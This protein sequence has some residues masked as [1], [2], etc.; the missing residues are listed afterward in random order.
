MYV[1]V[2]LAGGIC[3]AYNCDLY[4]NQYFPGVDL[5]WSLFIVTCLV[6]SVGVMLGGVISDR[7][8]LYMGVRGRLLVLALS[9]VGPA[10]IST[11]DPPRPYHELGK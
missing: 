11:L 3:F 10:C 4:Y 9:Q 5:G 1:F 2:S 6:G 8:V 7:F